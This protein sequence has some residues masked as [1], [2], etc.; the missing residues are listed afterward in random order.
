MPIASTVAT[1]AA[2]PPAV[3]VTDILYVALIELRSRGV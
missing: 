2:H 3:P 1:P